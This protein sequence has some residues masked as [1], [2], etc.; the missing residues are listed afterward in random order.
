M[1]AASCRSTISGRL[2]SFPLI[3]PSRCRSGYS[4][5]IP[6]L[7]W[8]CLS[9]SEKRNSGVR[10]GET[11][12]LGLSLFRRERHGKP[13]YSLRRRSFSLRHQSQSKDVGPAFP[14]LSRRRFDSTARS[15]RRSLSPKHIGHMICFISCVESAKEF[16]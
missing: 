14:Q 5:S 12:E 8:S 7:R 2:G 4:T 10:E 13:S 1:G 15:G 11:V 6:G 16:I 9:S 3:T